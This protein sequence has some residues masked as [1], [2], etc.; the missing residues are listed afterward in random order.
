MTREQVLLCPGYSNK[1]HRGNEG[2]GQ[3]HINQGT[4]Q[5][6]KNHYFKKCLSYEELY[7]LFEN[8]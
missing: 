2:E 4:I 8:I 5:F 7:E 1:Q 6:H 3:F